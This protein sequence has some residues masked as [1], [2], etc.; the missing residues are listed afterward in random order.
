MTRDAFE[1]AQDI[2]QKRRAVFSLSNIINNSTLSADEDYDKG[3]NDHVRNDNMILCYMYQNNRDYAFDPDVELMHELK[4]FDSSSISGKFSMSG[5]FLFGK[6][7]P[8]ELAT[9]LA[10]VIDEYDRELQDEFEKL[11]GDYEEDDYT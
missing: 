10:R 2:M 3:H 8:V 9:R 1:K 6:D 4:G 7:V 5:N 11:S